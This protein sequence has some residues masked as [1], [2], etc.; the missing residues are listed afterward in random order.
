MNRDKEG[1]A[2]M[3]FPR[4]V[5]IVAGD[6]DIFIVYEPPPADWSDSNCGIEGINL[7]AARIKSPNRCTDKPTCKARKTN[8]AKN[9]AARKSRRINRR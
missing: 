3:E 6:P 5:C 2:F 9:K 1:M 4:E 8:R 7:K